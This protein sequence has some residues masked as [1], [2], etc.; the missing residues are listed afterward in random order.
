MVDVDTK[1][2]Q[3]VCTLPDDI[4]A[5]TRLPRRSIPLK[6]VARHVPPGN[7]FPTMVVANALVHDD[8]V[9]FVTL[10]GVLYVVDAKTLKPVYHKRLDLN[11]VAFAYP[12]P[13]GSG[14][15]ASPTLGGRYIYL[16]GNGGTT[17]VIKPGRKY[18]LVAK[19]RIERLVPGRYYGKYIQLDPGTVHPECTVS[20][21]VFDGKRIYYQGEEFL[22]CIGAK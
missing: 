7:L 5:T 14:V 9:Y 12:Y 11:T 13:H 15:G 20:S 3:T 1:R 21:P 10:A 8:L 4:T 18:E 19:S 16:W 2:S 6:D 17:L 22:Y